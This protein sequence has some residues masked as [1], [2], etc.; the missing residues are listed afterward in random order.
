MSFSLRSHKCENSNSVIMH[1]W[2]DQFRLKYGKSAR[3]NSFGRRWL[4]ARSQTFSRGAQHKCKKPSETPSSPACVLETYH[5]NV[6]YPFENGRFPRHRPQPENP[7]LK[8]V[9][10]CQI[11]PLIFKLVDLK[12]GQPN[13]N[14]SFENRHFLSHRPPHF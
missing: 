12:S 1:F 9:T 13:S 4:V 14:V 8:I 7:G 11:V 2:Y 6:V 5:V 3:S 10:F